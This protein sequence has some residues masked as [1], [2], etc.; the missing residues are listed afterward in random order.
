MEEGEEVVQDCR[1]SRTVEGWKHLEKVQF[2]GIIFWRQSHMF[3]W[4][5]HKHQV[6]AGK[7]TLSTLFSHLGRHITAYD[8]VWKRNLCYAMSHLCDSKKQTKQ[9]SQFSLVSVNLCLWKNSTRLWLDHTRSCFTCLSLEIAQ[10]RWQDGMQLH[11]NRG[12][13]TG[14][15]SDGHWFCCCREENLTERNKIQNV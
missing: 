13:H 14:C 11:I 2:G 8:Q 4:E 7:K 10:A 6:T 12:R 3:P 5:R 9:S 1:T 15:L